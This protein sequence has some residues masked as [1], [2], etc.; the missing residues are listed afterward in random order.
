MRQKFRAKD[1]INDKQISKRR[2]EDNA[3]IER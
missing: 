2:T 3:Y 1:R